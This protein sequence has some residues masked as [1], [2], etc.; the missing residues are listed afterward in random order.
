M[1]KLPPSPS[2]AQVLDF[3]LVL[4]FVLASATERQY[5]LAVFEACAIMAN[6]VQPRRKLYILKLKCI[7]S[8]KMCLTFK[9]KS[10]RLIIFIHLLI[11][12]N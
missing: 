1:P 2:V 11:S 5:L 3:P 8:Y 4:Y 12:V 6:T 7:G 10:V 9:L